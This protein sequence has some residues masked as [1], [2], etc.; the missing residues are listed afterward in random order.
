MRR[1][2]HPMEEASGFRAMLN[3]EE[4]KYSMGR[5]L[6][7]PPALQHQRPGER[8]A[9]TKGEEVVERL[10]VVAPGVGRLDRVRTIF[11][12]LAW[13]GVRARGSHSLLSGDGGPKASCRSQ[14]YL[15]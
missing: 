6:P 7:C 5:E 3:L 2:V 13:A 10:G 11:R 4:P 8:P 14:N 15:A 9:G 1:D 12:S